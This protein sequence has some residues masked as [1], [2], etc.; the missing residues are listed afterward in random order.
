MPVLPWQEKRKAE[1]SHEPMDMHMKFNGGDFRFKF[2]PA[3]VG[4]SCFDV[5]DE[6]Q[7]KGVVVQ[8]DKPDKAPDIVVTLDVDLADLYLG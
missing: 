8:E 7:L 2:Q 3:E 1:T 4:S 5:F 6:I